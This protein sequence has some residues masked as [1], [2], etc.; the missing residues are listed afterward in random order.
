[1]KGDNKV[2]TKRKL[3]SLDEDVI[4]SIKVLALKAGKTESNYVNDMLTKII[5][6]SK[7][8]AKKG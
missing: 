5:K 1:L 8:E 7:N 2:M 6:Q 3:Y 4:I